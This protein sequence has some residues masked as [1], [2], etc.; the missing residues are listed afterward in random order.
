MDIQIKGGTQSSLELVVSC[1]CTE[2]GAHSPVH[3]EVSNGNEN[4]KWTVKEV[5]RDVGITVYRAAR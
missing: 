5:T 2:L 3:I 4:S 1:S